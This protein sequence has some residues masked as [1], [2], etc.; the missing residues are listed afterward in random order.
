MVLS[1]VCPSALDEAAAAAAAVLLSKRPPRKAAAASTV[2]TRASSAAAAAAAEQHHRAL[3]ALL[4]GNISVWSIDLAHLLARLLPPPTSAADHP[5]PPPRVLFCT[6]TVG[7]DASLA[8]EAFYADAIGEDAARV[9]ALFASAAASGVD[10]RRRSLSR[11]DLA[12]MV[13]GGGGGASGPQRHLA[14]VLVDK[15][16]LL[17]NGGSLAA[18][19]DAWWASWSEYWSS[20]TSSSRSSPGA[21]AAKRVRRGGGASGGGGCGSWWYGG[22]SSTAAGFVGHF[23]LVAG[24]DRRCREFLVHDPALPPTGRPQRVPEAV[25]DAA[26]LSRGTDED[27]LLVPVPSD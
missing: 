23:V 6:A 2:S 22:S 18:A 5:S 21:P 16:Q 3:C 13:S 7:V 4:G 14:V 25:L 10:V 26:R 20:G 1:A 27:V 24:Y 8:S 9:Q 15:R 12:A 17:T 19:Q 11:A